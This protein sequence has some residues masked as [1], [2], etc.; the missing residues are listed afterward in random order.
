MSTP[1]PHP[2]C[3]EQPDPECVAALRRLL[4]SPSVTL[5]DSAIMAALE[6]ADQAASLA[7]ERAEGRTPAERFVL[8]MQAAVEE[9]E[10]L[11][12]AVAEGEQGTAGE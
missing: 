10:G 7:W 2:A 1:S 3:P 12:L 8:A 4:T 6:W 9:L 5:H 11:S